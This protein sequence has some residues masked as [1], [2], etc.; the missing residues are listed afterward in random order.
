MS[1]FCFECFHLWVVDS[2]DAEP[3]IQKPSPAYLV[4]LNEAV[5]AEGSAECLR[6][7]SLSKWCLQVRKTCKDRAE[8]SGGHSGGLVRTLCQIWA[9]K[10]EQ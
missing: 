6:V 10:Q 3:Q 5:P 8:A 9:L 1:N 4:G 7:L 2:L